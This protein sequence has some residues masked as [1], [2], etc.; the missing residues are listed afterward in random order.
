[1][2]S[3]G[4]G[5][6]DVFG[7]DDRAVLARVDEGNAWLR[8]VLCTVARRGTL[9]R[10]RE[11]ERAAALIEALSPWPWF[12]GGQFL[13]DLMEWEDFMVDGPP[14]PLLA[15]VLGSGSVRRIAAMLAAAR[16][17]LDDAGAA[18]LRDAESAYQQV[19]VDLAHA[20][21]EL[22]D[23]EPGLYLYHDV[24]LGAV[25]SIGPIIV[26]AQNAAD[27]AGAT[28]GPGSDDAP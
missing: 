12:K 20:E 7:A 10:H 9:V 1:M 5:D 2:T 16:A 17:L 22:P 21:A 13:F 14:P 11:P 24:V 15:S 19:A 6:D 25:V 8:A 4:Q 27:E 26:S 23:L 3:T 18:A 28:P